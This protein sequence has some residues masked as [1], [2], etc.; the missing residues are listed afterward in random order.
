MGAYPVLAGQTA[1]YLYLQLRDFKEGRRQDQSMSPIAQALGKEEMQQLA[2]H[3]SEQKPKPLAFNADDAK[4]AAGRK[5]A[6][7]S[8]CSMCHLGGLAGQNEI[9]RL[10]GQQPE[11]VIKQLKAF[12]SKTRTNDAGNMAAY[13]AN[14]SDEDIDNLAQYITTLQ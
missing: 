9:P 13:T 8:L 3:F 6:E 10:A 4:V 1:R 5:K 12:R 11:Y 2:Q 14:L 7:E